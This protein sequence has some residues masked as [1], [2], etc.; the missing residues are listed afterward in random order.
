MV[1]QT[2]YYIIFITI[3][4]STFFAQSNEKIEA[5][6]KVLENIRGEISS[7]QTKLS[8][9]SD[10]EKKSLQAL[11][12]LNQQSLLIN[13]LITKLKKE[14]TQK[15]REIN[16]LNSDISELEG[17]I[18][19]LKEDYARYIIWLYKN[20]K[21]SFLKFLLN[22]ESINQALIRYK[23]LNYISDEKEE[24]LGQLVEKKERIKNLIAKREIEVKEK[25]RVVADKENEQLALNEK[26]SSSETLIA[27]LEK[28]QNA[29][30]E[31]IDEKRKAEIQIKNL[32]AKLIEDERKRLEEMR[33]ARM[34]DEEVSE[35][36][37]YEYDR[38]ENFASLEG[39]LNWPVRTGSIIRN[40]GEN[41]N[42]KLN[43]VTLNYGID[44][45]TGKNDEVF[46]VAEGIVSAIEWIP[47]YGSVVIITHK[48]NFRTVYG[49][50]SDIGI[51]E[52]EKVNGG[53]ILGKVN[54]SLEGNII[55]F[56]IWNERNYQNPEVWLVKK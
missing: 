18:S 55:H 35:D 16:S 1:K 47:G 9:L 53:T 29:L 33:L 2:G 4:A 11:Q 56:E 43:T 45:V 32:V 15:A 27:E 46:S 38:F 51:T 22:A 20:R 10:Q 8:T 3:F 7:L 42:A 40:F 44:I 54:Q 28:D 5:Q 34:N 26:K 39:N 12:N 36:Y 41:R 37:N 19:S 24:T 6:N 31:E 14:E 30:L 21:G 23:Y 13:Q 49:H 25:A 48:N 50:L 52:G 17:E